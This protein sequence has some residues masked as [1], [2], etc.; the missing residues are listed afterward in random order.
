MSVCDTY[1]LMV[2]DENKRVLQPHGLDVGQL[3]ASRPDVC[4]VRD[5]TRC[6]CASVCVCACARPT[7]ITTVPFRCVLCVRTRVCACVY[8]WCVRVRL[9]VRVCALVSACVCVCERPTGQRVACFT[10]LRHRPPCRHA[11]ARSNQRYFCWTLHIHIKQNRVCK[12]AHCL[13]N[14]R[15]RCVASCQ[16]VTQREPTAPFQRVHGAPLRG[17]TNPRA[18]Q[19]FRSVYSLFPTA[20]VTECVCLCTG[21]HRAV[22][23]RSA[24]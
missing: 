11:N 17:K 3:D 4:N 6:A 15:L 12:A 24:H 7:S 5:N 16:S 19:H 18:V 13:V 23:R 20:Y 22:E 2:R 9:C 21:P 1:L 14:L 8:V 10:P